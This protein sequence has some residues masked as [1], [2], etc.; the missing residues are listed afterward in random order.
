MHG[1]DGSDNLNG[2]SGNDWLRG[3]GSDFGTGTLDT[4]TGGNGQ[5]TFVLGTS[6][7][8]FYND[9]DEFSSGTSDR[10]II[11]D[12]NRAEDRIQL[13]GTASD[14]VLET[15]PLGG[16]SDTAIFLRAS[17]FDGVDELVAIV[18]NSSGLILDGS[19]FTFV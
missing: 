6:G 11:A 19:Y 13:A 1:G 16:T 8:A 9:L 2:G 4:L 14:Y 10:A 15:S 7:G 3:V 17:S 18:R 12:F 5:D